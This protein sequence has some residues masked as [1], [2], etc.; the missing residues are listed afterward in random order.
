MEDTTSR[1]MEDADGNVIA[2]DKFPIGRAAPMPIADGAKQYFKYM[3]DGVSGKFYPYTT[4]SAIQGGIGR[5]SSREILDF[6]TYINDKFTG[7]FTRIIMG[8]HLK[9]YMLSLTKTAGNLLVGDNTLIN[10]LPVTYM[11]P[12]DLVFRST[13]S[14]DKTSRYSIYLS[15]T[16]GRV[17]CFIKPTYNIITDPDF[18]LVPVLEA[19]TI[20]AFAAFIE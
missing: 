15:A 9:Y 8:D 13:I 5:G 18:A 17:H 10:Q 7:S 14:P 4:R 16:D 1:Y 3:K 20:T 11:P 2:I 6:G 19:N 12:K